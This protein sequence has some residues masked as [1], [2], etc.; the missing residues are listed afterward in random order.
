MLDQ[1][2]DN[3]LRVLH[4]RKS[5]AI[6]AGLEPAIRGVEIRSASNDFIDLYRR[7]CVRVASWRKTRVRRP[8]ESSG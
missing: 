6:P 8:Q 2:E 3:L 4:F 1:N 5:V 7:C